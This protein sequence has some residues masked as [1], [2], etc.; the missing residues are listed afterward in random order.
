VTRADNTR[1]LA[2]AAAERHRAALRRAT[3]AIEHLDR[4]GE[5]VTFSA[6]A[7]AGRVSRA[8][9]Y[10]QADLR[11]AIIRLRPTNGRPAPATAANQRASTESLRQRLDATRNEITQLRAE[12]TRLREQVARTLGEQRARH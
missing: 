11:A 5:A 3:A 9:L 12:N 2:E 10:R 1:Y 7:R 8:W 6:V 4:G